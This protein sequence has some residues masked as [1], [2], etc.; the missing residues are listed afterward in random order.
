M[1]T[2]FLPLVISLTLLVEVGS[3]PTVCA[4]DDQERSKVWRYLA[5]KYDRDGDSKLT[6]AEY[7]RGEK[8]F[9]RLDQNKDGVLTLED[10]L[11]PRAWPK[12]GAAP[13]AP[14]EGTVAPDFE[15]SFVKYPEKTARLSSFRGKRPVALIF[16]SCT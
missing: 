2:S 14:E 10:W 12:R 11:V 8:T 5:Q 16:G 15:L 1:R 4:E 3:P 13:K 9:A 6:P 7:D